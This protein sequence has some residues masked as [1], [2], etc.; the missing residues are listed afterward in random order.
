MTP[1]ELAWLAGWLEGEGTFYFTKTKSS[2]TVVIQVFSVDFDVIE[3]AAKLMGGAIY[4]IKP[5]GRSQGGFRVHLESQ[6][7]VDLMNDL[8]PLMGARRVA[9]IQIALE[10]WRTRPNRPTHKLCACGCGREVFGRPRLIYARRDTGACAMNAYRKRQKEA[11][12]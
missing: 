10:G 7:A 11:A 2:P 5:R 8:L 3:K 9:Q 6:P 4:S 12:A 1:M